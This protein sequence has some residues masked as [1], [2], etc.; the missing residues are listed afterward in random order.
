MGAKA[1]NSGRADA[2][3]SNV[4]TDPTDT[5]AKLSLESTLGCASWHPCSNATT[6]SPDVLYLGAVGP[7][8]MI[9][10]GKGMNATSFTTE[11]HFSAR[12]CENQVSRMLLTE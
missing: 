12:T 1:R 6:T 10:K 5:Y 4:T 11:A 9:S 2:R 8:V 3:M 7:V